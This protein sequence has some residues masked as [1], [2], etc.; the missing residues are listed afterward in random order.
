MRTPL[1]LSML[2]LWL[3]ANV[4][5]HAQWLDHPWPGIPRTADGKPNLTAPAPRTADGKPDFSGVW[6]LDAGPSL[7]WIAAEPKPDKKAWLEK[8]LAERDENIQLDDPG[9]H[10][11]PE[12]PRFMHFVAFPKKIVQTPALMTVMGEDLTYR[13]IFLDGRPLPKDPTPSFMGYSVGHWEGNTLVVETIGFKER[14]WLDF[15][16]HPHSEQLRQIERW[17][18]VNLGR[19]EIDETLTD[20]EIYSKPMNVKVTGT[21]VADT[22]LLEYVCAE[23]ERDRPKL[24]GTASALRKQYTPVKV[25]PEVLAQYVGTYDFRFPENPTIPSMWQVNLADGTLILSGAPLMPLSET[26]FLFGTNP[27]EFVKDA[28]GRVTHFSSTFVEGDL[29]GRR[30]SDEEAQR[31]SAAVTEEPAAAPS[32][33]RYAVWWS[34]GALVGALA[35]TGVL[36]RRRPKRPEEPA[37]PGR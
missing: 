8:L 6:G 21:L 37:L 15:A 22:D 16:G 13:Q 5:L 20:P 10:C 17:R 11:L 30:L 31:A 24:I 28:Q 3:C 19:I 14:T 12:G 18:R 2:F 35:V 27:L 25:A 9:L 33:K 23:N 32:V 7:F 34:V 4:P 1:R 36:L 26:R 29:I